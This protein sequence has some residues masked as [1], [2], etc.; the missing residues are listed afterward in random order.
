MWP[1]RFANENMQLWLG[2]VALVLCHDTIVFDM[3]QC[4]LAGA[5]LR[6]IMQRYGR[7]RAAGVC[8]W[9]NV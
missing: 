8:N 3:A 1:H 9:R 7:N 2:L 5:C 6:R 4:A